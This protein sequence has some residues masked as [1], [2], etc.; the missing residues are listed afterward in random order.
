MKPTDA[1]DKSAPGTEY[2]IYLY[3][4]Y[5]TFDITTKVDMI[6]SL[7]FE[8]NAVSITAHLASGKE[9]TVPL[10]RKN[11]TEWQKKVEFEE[12]GGFMRL[13]LL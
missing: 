9:A 4:E 6:A 12:I 13:L 10:E 5:S 8:A 3:P 1:V 7:N 2:T 11:T